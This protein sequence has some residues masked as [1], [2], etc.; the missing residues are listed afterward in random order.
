MKHTAGIKRKTRMLFHSLTGKWLLIVCL[1]VLPVNI[2]TALM[3]G[4]MSHTY[5]ENLMVS[6]KGQLNIY[7]ERVDTELARMRSLAQNFMDGSTLQKL[8]WGSGEDSVVEVTRFKNSLTGENVWC[9]YPG[10]CY[11]WDREKDIISFFRQG[12]NYTKPEME[13]IEE[14]LR[15][16]FHTNPVSGEWTYL[17]ADS[18]AFFV[19]NYIFSHFAFGILIDAEWVLKDFFESVEESESRIY[20]ADNEGTALS[21]YDENGFCILKEEDTV[22]EMFSQKDHVVLNGEIVDGSYCLVQVMDRKILMKNLPAMVNVIYVLTAA[23]FIV[24]PLVC[25]FT[26]WLVIRPLRRLVEAMR[27]LESGNMEYHLVGS[28]G[29]TELDFLYIS[30]NHMVD[31]LNRLVISSYE[32]EIEKLQTD[33][34]NM[35]LQVNQHMLL[36]FLNTIYNLS[37]VGKNEQIGDFTQLLMKYFRYVLRQDTALVPVREEM[38]FVQDYLKIQ[39]VRFPNSFTIVYSMEEEAENILIPQLLIEN[40]VENT[41]KYG[42]IMGTEI[43]IIINVRT[44]QD[45]LLISVCDTGTG[46]EEEILEKLNA[47]EILEDGTGK[48]IGIWNCR[49]RMKYYY[50]E[51]FIMQITSRPGEGTQV[52]IELPV[53]PRDGEEAARALHRQQKEGNADEYFAGR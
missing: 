1:A 11:V 29:S 39:K 33:S 22:K 31:E 23:S 26:V 10:L 32:R 19:E 21:Y 48:H 2:L 47:G 7:T 51:D 24:L 34:I 30:Y 8:L 44:Q 37:Q 52:W 25:I 42:I 40:F 14:C 27:L 20:L 13:Q 16:V 50:G 28:A 12:F 3:A 38:D 36:N 5:Q 49:R 9:S 15:E 18:Q 35:R 6:Y 46:M 43:E 53:K 4:M 45:R 41:I 17:V